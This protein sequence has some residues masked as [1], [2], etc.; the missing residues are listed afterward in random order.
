MTPLAQSLASRWSALAVRLADRLHDRVVLAGQTVRDAG[1]GSAILRDE[2]RRTE[3]E[4]D[5][6]TT[7]L[8]ES[9]WCPRCDTR[10]GAKGATATCPMGCAA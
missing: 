9:E 5:W 6:R 8:A 3:P 10:L 2:K 4:G 7:L 1:L